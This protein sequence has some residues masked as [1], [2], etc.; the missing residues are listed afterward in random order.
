M[1]RLF[2][3][4]LGVEILVLLATPMLLITIFVRLTSKGPAFYWSNRIGKNNSIFKMPKFRS[5]LT[6]APVVATHLLAN[7]CFRKHI[8]G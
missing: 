1:K 5:M 6:G 7:S 2:D 8:F 4:L 3:L